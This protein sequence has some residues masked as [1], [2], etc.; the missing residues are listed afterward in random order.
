MTASSDHRRRHLCAVLC[1]H[2]HEESEEID[3]QIRYEKK[4]HKRRKYRC[5]CCDH[6]ETSLGP[7]RIQPG[8]RY[9]I[10][11]AVHVVLMKYLY[12]MPWERLV[13]MMRDEGLDVSSMV[14]WQQS[15]VV[16]EILESL[17][18]R[19]G[20]SIRA[21]GH[22]SID[23][24]RWRMMGTR[25]RKGS[26]TWQA[27]G[28]CNDTTAFYRILDSRSADAAK[29]MLGDFDGVVMSDGYTAYDSLRKRAGS[30]FVLAHC[31]AHSRRKYV[32]ADKSY[33]DEAKR[34]LKLI[35][36]L[37]AI[38]R[39]VPRGPPDD[40][41]FLALRA[42]LR[43]SQSRAV[44]KEI[45][46]T[47]LNSRVMPESSIG[48]AM[49]YTGK[50]WTGLTRFLDDPKIE[51]DN[52]RCERGIRG[53]VLGRK[54]FGGSRSPAGAKTASILYSIMESAKLANVSPKKYVTAAVRDSLEGREPPLPHDFQ[55]VGE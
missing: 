46:D 11:F 25:G 38:E 31:W 18:E 39:L 51:L 34:M 2:Q 35:R 49:R 37:Y 28:M 54:N 24:T 22:L 15:R 16:S 50:Y 1:S 6:I 4:V 8:S 41:E 7:L 48:K 23:E 5:K 9:S 21:S 52:N 44:V 55:P 53:L 19:L 13:R 14:L 47:I 17:H 45:E 3:V 20:E 30:R 42:E 43:Q 40:L 29:L 26:E 32:E 36:N 33:P 12:H 27:W 10:D